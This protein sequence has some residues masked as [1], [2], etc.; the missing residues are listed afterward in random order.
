MQCL[1][2][3]RQLARAWMLYCAE[4]S[5]RLP[6]NF[7]GLAPQ[8]EANTNKTWCIGWLDFAGGNGWFG[9]N[10]A[11]RLN[12]D[13]NTLIVRN[14]LLGKYAANVS[15]YKCPSDRSLSHRTYGPPRVRS[16]S[17]NSYVGDRDGSWTAG[18]TQ[19]KSLPDMSF[20][21]PSQLFVFLDER[22]ESIND[23]YFATDM[24]GYDPFQPSSLILADVP[25]DHHNFACGFGFADGHS[26]IHRW[27]DP[28]T[29][30]ILKPGQLS[31]SGGSMPGNLDIEWL[32]AH[33]SFKVKDPSR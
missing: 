10:G 21:G 4:N 16:V 27:V 7:D 6:G 31:I 8:I 12:A 13:T 23:G 17:M 2:N 5:D 14:S 32:Q 19:F 30:P 22:E 20:H 24:T 18:Y 26:E 29:R 33:T 11:E 28:R 3:H 25:A 1:N 15:I 9:I